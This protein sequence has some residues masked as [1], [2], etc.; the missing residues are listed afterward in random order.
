MGSVLGRQPAVT[1]AFVPKPGTSGTGTGLGAVAPAPAVAVAATAIPG[2]VHRETFYAA[3]RRHRRRAR[4]LSIVCLLP[5]GVLALLVAALISP[6]FYLALA[7]GLRL[8]RLA[9]PLHGPERGVA[10]AISGLL[11]PLRDWANNRPVYAK[12]IVWSV[13]GLVLPSVVLLSLLWLWI[14]LRFRGAGT[15]GVLLQLGARPPRD[16]DPTEVRLVNVV[17]EMAIAAGIPAP[18]VLL[19]DAEGVNAAI[20]GS[21]YKDCALVVS[22]RLLE[23]LNRDELQAVLGDLIA[24]AGN[25]DLRIALTMLSV[26]QTIGLVLAGRDVLLSGMARRTVW[27]FLVVNLRP[28]KTPADRAARAAAASD[29]ML[30]SNSMDGLDTGKTNGSGTRD[31][32]LGRLGFITVWPYL[33]SAMFRM[34]M[35][36]YMTFLTGPLLGRIWRTRRYLADATAVQLTRNPDGL[37]SALLRLGHCNTFLP[38]GGAAA[39]LFVVGPEAMHFAMGEAMLALRAD[40]Q[41]AVQQLQ[42]LKGQ[43][44][45]QRLQALRELQQRAAAQ[46]LAE[47][48]AH[49][50]IAVAQQEWA[51]AK[52]ESISDEL[53]MHALHPPLDKRLKRLQALGSHYA[54]PE[55]NPNARTPHGRVLLYAVIL[56]FLLPITA[57]LLL[58]FSMI[59]AMA[60]VANFFLALPVLFLAAW[61]VTNALR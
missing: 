28:G 20:V 3:Q 17:E 40:N 41:A 32:G 7:G 34:F 51:A 48:A 58:A 5:I 27:R 6:W 10:E 47:Q 39:H 16:A 12:D 11:H 1:A 35:L 33:A 31:P 18:R 49:P 25:G 30:R 21:S 37:G 50:E 56:L 24:S 23:T 38:G 15:G 60:A 42:Q 9:G 8:L 44:M 36:F 4:L 45:Q 53:G 54:T 61:L 26:F 29:L 2:P 19:L 43:N 57:L 22:R 14:R 55:G 46:M 59:A 13:V 52:T